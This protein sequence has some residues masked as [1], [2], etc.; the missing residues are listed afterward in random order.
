MRGRILVW[1]VLVVLPSIGVGWFTVELV[2]ARLSDRVEANL[3]NARRL[4]AARI[5]DALDGYV[6]DAEALTSGGHVIDFVSG[7]TR[8]R[9]GSS[10]QVIGG[11]DGFAVVDPYAEA[12][13]AELVDALYGKAWSTG[14]EVLDLRVIGADGTSYGETPNFTWSPYDPSV[15]DD[16]LSSGQPRFGNAFRSEAGGDRLALV[17]PVTAPGGDVVGALL[18]ET[19]LGPIVDLVVEHEGFGETSEAHIAQPT[20]DGDA[21]FITLL[22]FERDAAFTK[23]VP[24]A[25][26]LPINQSLE[27]PVGQVV[28]SPDYRA[29]D[30]ILAIETLEATGWGLVVKIDSDEAFA[31]VAEVRRAVMWAGAATVLLVV[32]FAAVLLNPLAR[33]V[34][35]LSLAAQQIAAGRYQSSIGDRAHDEIGELSR[36][37]DQLA[38]DLDADIK[39]RALAEQ[40]LRHQVTHDALTGIHNRHYA[41]Q[42]ID[43]LE[44]DWSVLFLDLDS[45]KSINDVHGH[46]VG[47]EVL[48]A[49]AGRLGTA[50]PDGATVARWGGDEFVIVL[51]AD[52]G[53]SSRGMTERV[54]RLFTAPVS[55]SAGELNVF[56]SVGLATST[57]GRGSVDD[58]LQEA[59]SA[60]FAEKPHPRADRR[61]WSRSERAIMTGLSEGRI[62]AWYQPIF[63]TGPHHVTLFGAEVLA[64]MQTED[65]SFIPAAD[66]L[67]AIIDPAVGRDLDLHITRQAAAR[68]GAWLA[69]GVVGPDFRLSINLGVG[70]LSD[71][72]I[73]PRFDQILAAEGLPASMLI[74]EVSEMAGGID[75]AAVRGLTGIGVSTAID[76]VGASL[77][78][79]DRLLELRPHYAKLDRQWLADTADTRL[80]LHSLVETCQA[81]DLLLVA[82]GIETPAQHHLAATRDIPFVQGFLFGRAVPH[83]DFAATWLTSTAGRVQP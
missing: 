58:V 14:S 60:M 47:D 27:S 3:A 16:A 67:P 33:R 10:D 77:S 57:S 6:D 43:E 71:R 23:V 39:M 45:F 54:R 79:Y 21:E 74:A 29:V 31:P 69:H 30:S 62:E 75:M 50:V 9:A 63:T 11:Y 83:D 56:C 66:F 7:V 51:P 15:I 70:S 64:R 44:G 32:V 65:G 1:L 73:G 59:D 82:E 41:T 20:A 12:P 34:R 26:G 72:E 4:E 28:R 81:L 68:A 48:Q 40:K 8:I 55:T 19:R 37:I 52:C 78:N 76:D 42:R 38:A 46:G 25:K 22:R 2:G 80:V 36:S 35:R 53:E 24:S 13:L 5:T 18:L 49:V 61:T 17:A